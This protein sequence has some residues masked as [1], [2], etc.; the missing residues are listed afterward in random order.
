MKPKNIVPVEALRE[1][2]ALDPDLG[3]FTWA[4]RAMKWFQETAGR[5]AEQ[6]LFDWA[7]FGRSM[8]CS[9]CSVGNAFWSVA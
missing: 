5:S 6:G 1:L 2:L 7:R 8:S 4:P 3:T 9:P